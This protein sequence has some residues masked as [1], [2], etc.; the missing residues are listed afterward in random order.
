[1][2]HIAS[3]AISL[4]L[5]RTFTDN[6]VG[7]AN[8]TGEYLPPFPTSTS[9]S[10]YPVFQLPPLLPYQTMLM[11]HAILCGVGFLIILPT[12]ALI[13]RWGR[14]F[15]NSWFRAHW[16]FQAVFGIPIITAGWFLAVA[17]VV[18]QEGR[19]FDDTHKVIGLALFGAYILQLLLGVHIHFF[20]PP[21]ST[22]A[23]PLPGGTGKASLVQMIST[24]PRPPLNYVHAVLGLS[25]LT[26]AFY[27]VTSYLPNH[28]LYY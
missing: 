14:V 11:A 4:D 27:Q 20:K 23:R 1:M 16:I 24:S 6:T 9:G 15:T 25:I 13:A 7:T 26:L 10:N 19:H 22:R 21:A 3:G 28:A 5:S 17:G 12:G 18:T 2:Q 8:P